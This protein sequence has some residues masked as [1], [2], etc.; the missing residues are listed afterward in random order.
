M[1]TALT[2]AIPLLLSCTADE[3]EAPPAEQV[4]ITQLTFARAVDGVSLGFDLDG[5][6]SSSD[7]I[8]GCGKNDFVDPEGNAASTTRR[9]ASW[10]CW[11]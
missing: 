4:V 6:S 5:R 9:R 10:A 7:D 2:L 3:A 11:S 8:E 1:R